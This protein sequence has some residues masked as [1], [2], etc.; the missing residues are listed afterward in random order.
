MREDL[1]MWMEFITHPSVYSRGFI[2]FSQYLMA[3]EISMY[4]DAAKQILL[5]FGGMCQDSWTF[6]QWDPDFIR[7]EDPSIA[8]LELYALTVTIQLWIHRYRNNRIILFCDNQS[9]MQMVNNT[10]SKCSKCMILIRKLV[11]VSLKENVRIFA[12]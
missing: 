3:T 11:L 5:G 7:L 1:A 2:D 12:K 6:A 10:T 4:S 8:F 9:M